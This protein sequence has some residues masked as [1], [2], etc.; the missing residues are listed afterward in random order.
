MSI[1]GLG[2]EPVSVPVANSSVPEASCGLFGDSLSG[3][4]GGLS[5][6][7]SVSVTCGA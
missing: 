4:A 3:W 6:S 7:G 5:A 1:A 2:G